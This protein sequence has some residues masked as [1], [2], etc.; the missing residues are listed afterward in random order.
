MFKV[1]YRG[2]AP[3]RLQKRYGALTRSVLVLVWGTFQMWA[4]PICPHCLSLREVVVTQYLR[5]YESYS[6]PTT[7][8]RRI[9]P[10]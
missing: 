1:G 2:F 5:L 9:V 6:Y 4:L 8:H 3:P 10:L 7:P